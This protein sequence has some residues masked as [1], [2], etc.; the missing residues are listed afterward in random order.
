MD[1][2]EK[3]FKK[4]FEEVRK[5]NGFHLEGIDIAIKEAIL[6]E[7]ENR[8]KKTNKKIRKMIK[9]KNMSLKTFAKILRKLDVTLNIVLETR[10]K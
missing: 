4:M 2:I 8:D 3:S 5:T 7:L 1:K 6:K 10:S 9:C